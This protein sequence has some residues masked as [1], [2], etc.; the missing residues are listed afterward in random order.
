MMGFEVPRP[1]TRADQWVFFGFCE[2]FVLPQ[3]YLAV[4]H[5][6]IHVEIRRMSGLQYANRLTNLFRRQPL[7]ILQFKLSSSCIQTLMFQTAK[8]F[9][10]WRYWTINFKLLE[11]ILASTRAINLNTKFDKKMASNGCELAFCVVVMLVCWRRGTDGLQFSACAKLLLRHGNTSVSC[12]GADDYVNDSAADIRD[13]EAVS[14][15]VD[16]SAID[17]GACMMV[18]FADWRTDIVVIDLSIVSSACYISGIIIGK[19]PIC[20]DTVTGFKFPWLGL[21]STRSGL[22]TV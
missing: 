11:I 19:I 20:D 7:N 18:K 1:L 10:S 2:Q 9:H 8:P 5:A 17:A 21:P 6:I 14:D 16:E 4:D 15:S 12:S 13:C 22:T 3:V